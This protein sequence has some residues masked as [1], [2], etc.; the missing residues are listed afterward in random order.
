MHGG[1]DIEVIELNTLD[2]SSTTARANPSRRTL[3]RS[4][5]IDV[6]PV[7]TSCQ[8]RAPEEEEE[9]QQEE[10][11]EEG[12]WQREGPHHDYDQLVHE[13]DRTPLTGGGGG[14]SNTLTRD[15][16]YEEP[17]SPDMARSGWWWWG[18]E[19]RAR[20]YEEPVTRRGWKRLSM[21]SLG[22]ATTSLVPLPNP[23]KRNS[24]AT[25]LR[26]GFSHACL[27]GHE[28]RPKPQKI[29]HYAEFSLYPKPTTEGVAGQV[30]SDRSTTT[31]NPVANSSVPPA[32]QHEYEELPLLANPQQHKGLP[33]LFLGPIPAPIRLLKGVRGYEVPVTKSSHHHQQKHTDQHQQPQGVQSAALL[34]QLKQK[35][36]EHLAISMEESL[37]EEKEE[38]AE[39]LIQSETD[40]SRESESPSDITLSSQDANN[41]SY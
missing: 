17:T 29:L 13:D 8:G 21:P 26:A 34:D 33:P 1:G 35:L 27:G 30:I 9:E 38:E 12:A 7:V 11:E 24:S 2:H 18:R 39:K 41:V 28:L 19:G 6:V 25:E 32:K 40:E 15:H 36:A 5:T 22:N 23:L 14:R 37:E 10:Q 20:G 16:D 4:Y 31:T 3:E